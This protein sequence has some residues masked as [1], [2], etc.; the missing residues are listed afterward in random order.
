MNRPYTILSAAMSVDGYID[1]ASD[2]RLVLSGAEDWDRVDEQRAGVD[3]IMV[4]A[5]TIRKDN[6]RLRVRSETRRAERVAR[7]L[8]EN[9]LRVTCT[10]SGGLDRDAEFFS[11]DNFV[12]Y[13]PPAVPLSV[14]VEDLA[15]RGVRRL[16]V[17]GGSAVHTA[18]LTQ[19][20][21]DEIQLAV[22]P[23]FVGDSRAP[24]FVQDGQF[25]AGRMVLGDVRRVGDVT[26]MRMFPDADRYW[27]RVCVEESRKCP[28]SETAFPVGA[29]IVGA[30]GA[31]IARG[32][33]RETDPTAHAEEE[34][35]AKV[36]AGD[37]R[38]AT[39]T[40]Y[41][42]LEPCST[43]K[44]RPRSCSQWIIDAGIP[45][46]VFGLREPSRFVVGK[47]FETLAAAG[48]TVVERPDIAPEVKQVSTLYG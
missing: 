25:D 18:F 41:S 19:N 4:G 22:A 37:P 39:A 6:P 35:L 13:G 31:E 42:S 45:R 11:D 30:D 38:L 26:V 47:G 2:A 43:R 46:A 12:V 21:A 33:S 34:A 48:V 20:L 5:N 29:V 28:P 16:M 1:D 15:R 10:A 36:G 7:G 44:S 3:A 23:V 24:R 8:P 32:Y 27:L 17:E 14:V 40:I 9:P